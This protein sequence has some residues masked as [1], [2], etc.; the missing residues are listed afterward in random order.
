[1]WVIPEV[2]PEFETRMLDVLEQYERPLN[3][4]EPVICLD[5]KNHQLLST[6]RGSRPM[7]ARTTSAGG[8]PRRTDYEYQRVSVRN[9]FV[10]LEP[11]A[12]R[13]HIR[14]T[15]HRTG[16][17]WAKT[18]RHLVTRM[19]PDATTIHVVEDN[20]NTHNAKYLT[21]VYG[22][23]EAATLLARLKF[24]PTPKHASWL[25]MA[26]I[27]IGSFT[28]AVL[29][30]RVPTDAM[31]TTHKNAYVR[32]RNLAKATV[33]WTFTPERARAKFKLKDLHGN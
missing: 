5:E 10:I 14:T 28:R 32:R 1:M 23:V 26:E 29:K 21:D 13:R 17:D 9:E 3:P 11:K 20:L 24:H 7:R 19:Y 31:L 25:N 2:T 30:R 33:N 16:R 6:P 22:Q 27:E 12:G 4:Q 15:K 8:K 18:I